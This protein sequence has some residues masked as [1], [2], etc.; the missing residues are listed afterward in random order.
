MVGT[1]VG[2]GIFGIPYV[3]A[4]SGVV[5]SIFYFLLLLSVV[6]VLHLVY[7]EIVLRTTA[8]HRI[9]GYAKMYLGTWG[10]VLTSL[11]I[12]LALGGTL[13]A[14]LILSGR[15]LEI[16]FSSVLPFSNIQFSL[17]FLAFCSLFIIKGRGLITKAELFFN[18]GLFAVVGVIVFFALPHI[19]GSNFISFSP[20]NLLLP[21][22]VLLFT[23][24]G[25]EAI[26]E[27]ATFLKDAKSN[28]RLDK[29]II[30]ATLLATAL[31]FV[32]AFTVAGVS[33]SATSDDAFSGLVPILGDRIALLGAFLGLLAIASSFLV[34][35]NYLKNSL[36]HDFHIPTIPAVFI[37]LGLPLLPF[38]FGIREFIVV[39]GTVGALIGA[40]EGLLMLRIFQ[41][42][43][44]KGDRAPEYN[45]NIPRFVL[46][47]IALLLVGGAA[48]TL[49]L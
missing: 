32:F 26:P 41:K 5:P 1:I 21:Y 40:M 8:K 16:I 6:L 44:L 17:L 29:V 48:A 33:G 43:K 37:T 27:I 45:I 14:Y 42:A 34:I 47:F 3:V 25:W 46:F 10:R 30:T 39:I 12:L 13:L 9:V 49:L 36:R 22:G 7:G 20:N 19:Q 28:V 24:I 15:F 18:I 4:K 35:G 31:S 23:L 38:L 11:S 2:A